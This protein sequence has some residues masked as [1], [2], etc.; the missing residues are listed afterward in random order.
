MASDIYDFV[1][2]ESSRYKTSTV[3][4]ADGWDW[5]MYNHI[6]KSFLYKNSKFTDGPDDGNRPFEQI[7]L[8]I[9]TNANRS[10]NIDVKDIVPYVNDPDEYHKSFIVKKYHPSWARDNDLDTFLDDLVESY[11]DYGLALVQEVDG[12]RPSVVPLEKLAFVDQTDVLSG[13]ICIEHEFTPSELKKQKGWYPDEIERAIQ[14]I[15]DKASTKK[16]NLTLNQ[17]NQTP[18]GYVR[19][20]EVHGEFL[21][22][23]LS[24]D[25]ADDKYS[26]QM[27]IICLYEDEHKHKGG[28]C[29]YKGK[30]KNVFKALKR[31][32]IFGRACGR[33]GIEELF[34]SQVWTNYSAIQVKEMLDVA[35]LMLTITADKA[36]STRQKITELEKGEMIY[37]KE[38]SNTRQLVIQPINKTAFDVN[39]EKWEMR[40]RLVGAASE[41]QLGINPS[42]GT[43]LG[44]TQLVTSQGIGPH[45][46]RQGKIATFVQ[47]I[48]RDWVLKYLVEEINKGKVFMEELSL[49]ELQDVAERI[50]TKI[51]NGRI[52]ELV[53]RGENLTIEENEQFK[54]VVRENFFKQG[55]KRFLEAVKNELND[56]P[57][58]VFVNVKGKQKDMAEMANKLSNIVRTFIADPRFQN[59]DMSNL[60]LELLEN[61][62]LSPINFSSLAKV[63]TNPQPV[64]QGQESNVQAENLAPQTA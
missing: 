25:G 9:I 32:K 30:S 11:D 37:E 56:I 5:S 1:R 15:S 26:R 43:P 41:A 18:T 24:E 7:I 19:V 17:E 21:E 6:R 63:F 42:S 22:S 13:A 40:A 14:Y 59:K 36:L 38:G 53:L 20:F 61:S 48:Y 16:S 8:P 28:I 2:T 47:E 10:K 39:S 31:D 23:W 45:E 55:N 12:V 50:M 46:Y 57:T 54:L 60:L 62:G 35:S 51:T 33:G 49:D 27:H 29:L 44:T 58:D 4:L 3:K 52:K 64:S 34:E